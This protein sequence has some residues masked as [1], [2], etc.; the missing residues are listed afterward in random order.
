MSVQLTKN[1]IDLGI[2]TL[3]A[4]AALKFYRDLLGFVEEGKWEMPTGDTMYR[5]LCGE[6]MIKIVELKTPPPAQAPPGGIQ[7]ATGYRYWTM[8]IS[9]ITDMVEAVKDGGYTIVLPETEVRPGVKV[10]IV[11]DP[12]GN[13]V[14]FLSRQV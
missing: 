2:V 9:N 7:G 1:S 6:S 5:L 11:E 12:D 13:C 8:S 14:E 4:G 10:A 3:N